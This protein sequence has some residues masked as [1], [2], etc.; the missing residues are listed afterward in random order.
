MKKFILAI[1]GPAILALG[2]LGSSAAISDDAKVDD[3]L[4]AQGNS[5]QMACF[6]KL[7]MCLTQ[8]GYDNIRDAPGVGLPNPLRPNFVVSQGCDDA[9]NFERTSFCGRDV[10]LE[11]C[12]A[13]YALDGAT[14]CDSPPEFASLM[15]LL[16]KSPAVDSQPEEAEAF[17]RPLIR[18][19]RGGVLSRP[20]G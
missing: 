5:D 1:I 11:R 15:D 20:T 13:A 19:I 6:G 16:K 9:C 18:P 17:D 8:K 12:Y 7:H 10:C 3:L 2:F 4:I 14:S